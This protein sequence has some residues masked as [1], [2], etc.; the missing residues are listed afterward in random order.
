[1]QSLA[2][3]FQQTLEEISRSPETRENTIGAGG[4][5]CRYSELPAL[6]D[7][8]EADLARHGIGLG[9]CTA[10]ECPNTLPGTLL[11]LS[12]LRRG[13]SVIVAPPSLDGNE[14][15]PVPHF[16]RH[17]V[18]VT[19][20]PAKAEDAGT[21]DALPIE[22]NT[23]Y[24]GAAVPP[25]RFC[26][27]TS[28][29]MGATKIVS[30]DHATLIG[31]ARN[32]MAKYNITAKSR[33][34]IP[35]P[36]AHMYG[37]GAAFLSAFLAGASI[38]LQ[39]KTNLL[40][41][42]DREKRFEPDIVFSTPALCEMLLK[43]FKSARTGYR[44]F[45]A[46]GQRIGEPLFRAFDP[47]V[48]GALINQYGS[49]EMGATSACEPGDSLERRVHTIGEPMPGVDLKIEDGL[50]YCRHPFGFQGYLDEAGEWLHRQ[51]PGAW[52]RTGL[53]ARAR[54]RQRESQRISGA[55]GRH[56][57]HDGED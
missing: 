5:S 52:S 45:V 28:G 35:V 25:A 30:H 41:Y 8:T 11:L 31:N 47:M 44:A 39:E 1:L 27:R 16:C 40:K 53:R 3:L 19:A 24:N 21:A 36:I 26:L 55:V 15:K 6:L 12:L 32:V 14:T 13:N 42:L 51:Q 54:G 23:Q 17:R 20:A 57:T 56:R 10:V 7:K 18:K 33:V 43:G 29:S 2:I 4:V 50:L 37:F 48:G 34:A 46:S 22:T 38:D 9:T 49:T